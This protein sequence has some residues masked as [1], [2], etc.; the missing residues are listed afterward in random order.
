MITGEEFLLMAAP[1]KRA[2]QSG[3]EPTHTKLDSAN[4]ATRRDD[5]AAPTVRDQLS[6]GSSLNERVASASVDISHIKLPAGLANRY[7][8]REHL[9]TQGAE[10]DLFLVDSR[11]D[12]QRYVIKLYRKGIYP[13]TEVLERIARSAL[14]HVI[15]VYEHGQTNGIG[16]EVL[17][18]AEHGSL[19]GMFLHGRTLS[20]EIV[21]AILIELSE[22]LAHLHE[23]IVDGGRL[24]HRDIKPENIL[25]RTREPLDLVLTDFGITSVL[26][27]SQRFTSASRTIK[28]AAPEAGS[29]IV[30]PKADYW[31]LGLILIEALTGHHPFEDL[32]DAVINRAIA[33]RPIDV[34]AIPAP[35][36]NL[37]RGLLLR[38]PK[39]RWGNYEIRIWLANP[40][41]S[42]L[43]ISDGDTNSHAMQAD[44]HRP[45]RFVGI[46]CY[47]TR[48]LAVHLARHWQ[49]G[50]KDLSRNLILTWFRDELRD[51]DSTRFLM[52]LMED[53]TLTPDLRLLRFLLHLAPDMP[54]VWKGELVTPEGL[55]GLVIKAMQQDGQ[56]CSLIVE[57][58]DHRVLGFIVGPDKGQSPSIQEQWETI[59]REYEEALVKVP[60]VLRTSIQTVLPALLASIISKDFAGSL[61]KDAI[62]GN[63]D[64]TR[65]CPWYAELGDPTTIS[66]A[67]LLLM[68]ALAKNASDEGRSLLEQRRHEVHKR[69]AEEQQ[70]ASKLAELELLHSRSERGDSEAQLVLADR[71]YEGHGVTKDVERAAVSYK[72]AAEQG[73]AKAQY[74]M[75]KLCKE[76]QGIPRNLVIAATWFQKA[77]EQGVAAAQYELGRMYQ[78]GGEALSRDD[79]KAIEWL[80][81]SATQGIAQAQYELSLLYQDGRGVGKDK[82]EEIRWLRA[83]AEQGIVDA[84]VDLST[85]YSLG[86]GLPQ[87]GAKAAEW[88]QRVSNDVLAQRCQSIFSKADKLC[89]DGNPT[90]AYHLLDKASCICEG[91]KDMG[92]L[93][94]EIASKIVSIIDKRLLPYAAIF[95]GLLLFL[96]S[97]D[98]WRYLHAG[99]TLLA[100]LAFSVMTWKVTR[101]ADVWKN[102]ASVV[103]VRALVVLGFSSLS[104]LISLVYLLSLM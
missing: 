56:A 100:G 53:S 20:N 72:R 22:A 74:M 69:Q 6:S 54:P 62:A 79:S 87:N 64:V 36:Q 7:E 90:D 17:E 76:G 50:V 11:D 38:D 25:I 55:Q 63:T 46:N 26:D 102:K 12:G 43:R 28:Y 84:Q 44:P 27:A 51:Q 31:S 10:A 8:I 77:A 1:T 92:P 4:S 66:V 85:K 78:D 95:I 82:L 2:D 101:D 86:D 103:R 41:D 65:A 21:H 97:A 80:Q 9:P 61:R 19:K 98:S 75:G 33:T 89:K 45:Y 99:T 68:K 57:L 15:R 29:G 49:E 14:Q 67:N 58:Y 70:K 81:R 23:Q 48:E 47:T 91:L 18:Y 73:A 60:Q 59:A 16:Y 39:K 71:Y 93:K 42:V 88:R 3:S 30:D 34:S 94:D 13:K 83:A 35:W 96:K 24:V 32:S 37:C 5:S 52:D 104:L 40:N